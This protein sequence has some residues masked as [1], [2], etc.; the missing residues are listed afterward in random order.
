MKRSATCFAVND[1]PQG[2]LIAL[3]DEAPEPESREPEPGSRGPADGAA[4]GILNPPPDGPLEPPLDPTPLDPTELPPL[5]YPELLPP[6]ELLVITG[7]LL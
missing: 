1:E 4:E 2:F 6:D 3:G 5:E 7:E